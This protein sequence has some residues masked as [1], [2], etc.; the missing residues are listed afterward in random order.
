MSVTIVVGGQYGGEGKGKVTYCIAKERNIKIAVRVGGTNSGHTVVDENNTKFILRQ[1]PTTAI[2][3]NSISVLSSGSYIDLDILKEEIKLTGISINQ[4]II[5]KNAMIITKEDKENEA[6]TELRKEIG[7]TLSGTGQSVIRRIQRNKLTKL[8]KDVEELKPFI[9]NTKE[10]L[11]ERI[12]KKEKII[13][14]G[15]QGFGLS[16]IHSPHYPFTTSRDTTAAGF[17][18]EVGLSPFDVED[19]ILVI[20]TY[21][22]RVEGNSGKLENEI[23]WDEL[24]Q[25]P[26]FT[27][28]TKKMRRIAKFDSKIVKKA[29][30]ANRPTNIVLNHLD[31]INEV[32]RIKYLKEIE[33]SIAQ[34]VNYIGLDNQCITSI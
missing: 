19:I 14:E 30:I 26:E 28:V 6:S 4:L 2:L 21:P 34:K 24:E 17:L 25:L 22:I 27:S 31:Y 16:L 12:I 32:D 3:P 18:S 29:I 10:F 7:S 11:F 9:S 33:E 1:L 8:A 20:R 23:S 5:D 13:I 15:T